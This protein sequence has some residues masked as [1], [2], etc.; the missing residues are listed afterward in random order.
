M[1]PETMT[2]TFEVISRHKADRLTV[3]YRPVTNTWYVTWTSRAEDRSFITQVVECAFGRSV[4]TWV[5]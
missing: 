5:D 1:M 2:K 3:V 4:E